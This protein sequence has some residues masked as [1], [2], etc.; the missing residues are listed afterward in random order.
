M[1]NSER[2]KHPVIRAQ[3]KVFREFPSFVG[4]FPVL[5][6]ATSPDSVNIDLGF[7]AQLLDWVA[8]RKLLNLSEPRFPH[9]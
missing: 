2:V 7:E 4:G 3:G 8:L 9:F 5:D 1:P 6:L